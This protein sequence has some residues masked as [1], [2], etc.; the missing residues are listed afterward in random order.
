MLYILTPGVKDLLKGAY[1]Y[2]FLAYLQ[3]AHTYYFCLDSLESV[4]SRERFRLLSGDETVEALF[5]KNPEQ[6]IMMNR[7]YED[8]MYLLRKLE[9]KRMLTL[10][11]FRKSVKNNIINL[12][13]IL[14]LKHIVKRFLGVLKL[15]R[16]RSYD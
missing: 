2:D 7:V 10:A 1:N 3:N 13:E 5:T 9:L 15:T 16:I 12:L 6:R 14:H 11:G 4:F 8:T